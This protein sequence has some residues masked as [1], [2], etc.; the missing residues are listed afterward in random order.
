MT[1]I[2]DKYNEIKFDGIYRPN[3]NDDSDLLIKLEP[4]G[5]VSMLNACNNPIGT[6]KAYESGRIKFN[7][8]AGTGNDCPDDKDSIYAIVLNRS[9]IF[10]FKKDQIILYSK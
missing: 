2:V 5:K 4:N 10:R 8:F 6:Y 7:L 1:L 9:F 3:I